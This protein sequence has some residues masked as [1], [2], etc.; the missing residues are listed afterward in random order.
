[1]ASQDSASNFSLPTE[2]NHFKAYR[3]PW[4]ALTLLAVG[5]LNL[6]WA[7]WTILQE[8]K[9][10]SAILTGVAITIAGYLCLT[11]PYFVLAPN[12]L[13]IYSLIGSVVKRYPLASFS[14]LYADDKL[15]YI[16]DAYSNLPQPPA[17]H[18]VKVA[19]WL[20]KS[21][22]WNKLKAIISAT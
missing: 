7:I 15:L 21:A 8:S 19:K 22:D 11:G 10:N 18:P 16:E 17:K 12:R 5:L 2:D 13:T 9:F 1:M 4:I 20:T 14:H 6:A 3:A